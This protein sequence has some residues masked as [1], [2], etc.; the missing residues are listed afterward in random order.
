MTTSA[1][2]QSYMSR[3]S[4]EQNNS[5]LAKAPHRVID[6]TGHGFNAATT[7]IVRQVKQK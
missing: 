5:V 2:W 3:N 4:K 7:A 6:T 1:Q